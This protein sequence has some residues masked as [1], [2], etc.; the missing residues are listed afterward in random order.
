MAEKKKKKIVSADT[1]LEVEAGSRKATKM[2]EAA[3]VG[4]ASGL[5]WGAVAAPA[6]AKSAGKGRG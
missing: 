2:K 6:T 4:N 3:P 5:R 1:G